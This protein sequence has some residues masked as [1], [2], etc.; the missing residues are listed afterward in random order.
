MDPNRPSTSALIAAFGRAY[1]ATH[2]NPKIFDDFLA[3]QLFTAQ[4]R[5]LFSENLSRALAFFDPEAAAQCS[6]QDSALA[7][8]M[9]AQSLP[10]TLSRARY[11]E[12]ILE[13]EI[14][15]GVEQYVI[16]GAGLDTFAFRRTDLLPHLQVFELDHPATQNYKYERIAQIGWKV[17]TQLHRAP[18]DLNREDLGTALARSGYDPH[19]QSLFSWLGVTYYLTQAVNNATLR[20][21]PNSAQPGSTLIFDYLDADAFVR[22]RTAKRV[23]KMQ[24]ATERAGE[25]MLTGFDPS[26]L[27]TELDALGLVL[28]ENLGPCEIQDRYFRG[29]TDGYYAFEHIHFARATVK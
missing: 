19:R 4:E 13:R 21:I 16:L 24:E 17:P 28:Q 3:D 26:T 27:A 12:E 22:E 10:I 29:R 23:R 25:P 2:D 15:Q 11:V 6:D 14:K 8:F 20:A 9:R 18:L 1:H 7:G 5:E